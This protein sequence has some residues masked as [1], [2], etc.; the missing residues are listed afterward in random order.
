MTITA[1]WRHLL[2]AGVLLGVLSPLTACV[3]TVGV[4][5]ASIPKDSAQICAGHCQ[6]IGMYLSAVA[7]MAENV[8][9]VCQGGAATPGPGQAGALSTP[10]AGMATIAMQEQQR[11][12]AQRAAQQQQQQQR[13]MQ[14]H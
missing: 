3:A 9:C 8:G 5:N 6:S 1:K 14:R 4:A 10:A 2:R 13:Q 12:A 11:R 7:I